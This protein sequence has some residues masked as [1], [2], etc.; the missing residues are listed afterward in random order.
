MKILLI[1]S[2]HKP[3]GGT[4]RYYFDLSKLL[5]SK[6][7]KIAYFSMLDLKKEKTI[8]KR[9]FVSNIDFDIG[10]IGSMIRKLGRMFYSWE[11][12]KKIAQ[13]LDDFKPDI[14]HIN[15]IYFYISPSILGEIKK[16]GIPIVQTV[17]D[18]QL[19]SPNIILFYKGRICE[20]TKKHRYYKT[21]LNRNVKGSY[22]A[23][24]MAVIASYTQHIFRFYER[25][26]DLFIA[27]STFMRNKMIE[28]GIDQNK[29]VV[30]PNFVYPPRKY[31]ISSK[32]K[33]VFYF[34]RFNEHKGVLFLL[35]LAKEC[36][37]INIKMMGKYADRNV[38]IK[39][40]DYLRS[41]SGNLEVIA[42]QRRTILNKYIRNSSFVVVPSQ[43]YENQPYSILE[44]FAQGK[45]VVATNIGG[46]P[47]MVQ[48][49]KNGLL[50]EPGNINQFIQKATKLWNDP[51]LAKKF[52]QRARN[53]VSEKYNPELYY[54]KILVVYDGFLKKR[55]LIV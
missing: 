29:I 9:F 6:G 12:K 18:Y 36:P 48:D 33:Y 15:N 54:K 40:K 39:I 7:H 34:G 31:V 20:I 32:G 19:I 22:I 45:T 10:G 4:E 55:K 17:H 44:T 16:R 2:H 53:L 46:I 27:P 21:F 35:K 51:V 23:S 1:N 11:S 24:L 50:F 52:G 13:L 14:V 3:D 37:H 28:Y 41:G 26:I 38:E 47:E 8:W 5:K 43:W 30:F 42:H 25:H 49:G